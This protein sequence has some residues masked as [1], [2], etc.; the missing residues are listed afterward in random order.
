MWRVSWSIVAAV[1]VALLAMSAVYRVVVVFGGVTVGDTKQAATVTDVMQASIAVLSPVAAMIA[2]V[3][4][5]RRSKVNLADSRRS[6]DAAYQ[7]R[8]VEASTLLGNENP[9]VRVA[10]V[11]AMAALAR[12]WDP[13]RQR[14]V[15][16]LCGY[17]R[18]PVAG[19]ERRDSGE[20]FDPPRFEIADH[21][22]N[23][24][25][26]TLA[27]ELTRLL[28]EPLVVHGTPIDVD[29]HGAAFGDNAD[30]AGARFTG[31]ADF[32]GATFTG[33]ADFTGVRFAGRAY[34]WGVRFAGDAYFEGVTFAGDAYFWGVTFA[35]DADFKGATFAG[36]A[37]FWGVR[38]AGDAGFG[39]VTFAGDVGFGG[40]TFTS[41]ADFEGATFTSGAYFEGATFTGG[42]DFRRAT[43]TG[44]AYFGDATFTSGVYFEEAKF[45]GT[46]LM[47]GEKRD[48][49][50]LG[51]LRAA[52]RTPDPPGQIPDGSGEVVGDIEWTKADPAKDQ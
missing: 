15:D 46:V 44:V 31:D 17:M 10:A 50:P 21:G 51:P 33:D 19:R 5:Y 6:D 26:N 24:V 45:T 42:S 32:R 11:I 16:V 23:E 41:D 35:G 25:R 2:A 14:C 18:V 40:V 49:G 8:F 7:A 20:S 9:A 47:L 52:S 37:Y 29:L 30:F 38:F 43:F 34:F 1:G 13:H 36:D 48:R 28:A 22:E 39:G 4:L 27:R 12:D 3:F